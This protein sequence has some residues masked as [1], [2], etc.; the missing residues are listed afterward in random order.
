MSSPLQTALPY[1]LRD[2]K[3]TP[4][5]DALGQLLG[6]TSLDLPYSQTFSFSEAD[7]FQELRGDDKLITTH[8]RGARVSWSLASGGISLPAWRCMSGGTL[9]EEGVAPNRRSRL[10]KKSSDQ[11]PYFKVDGQS[12][13]DAGGDI[14]AVVFRCRATGDISG[15]FGDGEFFVTNASGD[16]LPLLDDSNDLLYDFIQ[17]E[18]RTTISLTPEAN[19]LATPNPPNVGALTATTAA[20]SVDPVPGATAYTFEK[21]ASPY[22]TFSSL[23]GTVTGTNIAGT[24]LTA[25]TPYKFRAK[26]VFPTGTSEGGAPTGVVTTPAA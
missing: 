22:T 6:T 17:N 25:A 19:P 4:Y 26:A 8:G 20:L 7:E 5:Q 16:G 3:L 21:A 10:R 1:G 23:T 9:S 12:I 24:G 14:R 11:R 18:Q 13:S 2:V 15:D